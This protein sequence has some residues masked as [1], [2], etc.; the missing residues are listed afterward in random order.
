MRFSIT[1]ERLTSYEQA[2]GADQAERFVSI[3]ADKSFDSLDAL[4]KA[5]GIKKL[6][7]AP[8]KAVIDHFGERD[9]AA[10]PVTDVDGKPMPDADLR[11]FENVPLRERIETYFER[12]VLPHVPDA[13]I[14]RDKLDERDGKVGI[15]GYEINFNR[16]FYVYQPPRPLVEIDAELKGVEAEIA[17][18]LSEVTR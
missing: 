9:P 15:V 4:L 6:P 2:K 7:K 5:A 8:R 16:Y 1:P 11:E 14:A 3:K 17:A 12:E 13:W 18:L 10:Q